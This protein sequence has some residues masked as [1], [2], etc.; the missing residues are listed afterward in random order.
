M[1]RVPSFAQTEE[2]LRPFPTTGRR[3]AVTGRACANCGSLE[4]RPSNR[5]NALDI[6]LACLFLAPFR[7]R[8]CRV[9]FYLFWR[10][11]LQNPPDPPSAPLLLIPPR[12]KILALDS[13][14]PHRIEPTPIQP[15]LIPST[16]IVDM[17]QSP[18]VDA[19]AAKPGPAPRQ[20]ISAT[21]GPILILESDLSIRKLLRRLLERRG[22]NTVEVAQAEDLAGEMLDRRVDLLVVDVSTVEA[23]VEAVV[24][25]ACALPSLKIL[26]LS[27]ERL[28]DNEMPDRLLVLPKPFPLDNFVD[29]VDR[30]L[31]PSKS[32]KTEL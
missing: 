24:K 14:E 20:L 27:S 2:T 18:L 7:C 28:P 30:L 19:P 11:S 8:V 29:C 3:L 6:L 13:I 15:Q 31:G 12:R 10:P 5:R 4:I 22:Y 16:K 9:R 25:L 1:A 23:G 17:V 32:P 21:P 26:A